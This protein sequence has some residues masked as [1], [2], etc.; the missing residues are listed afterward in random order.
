MNKFLKKYSFAILFSILSLYGCIDELDFMPSP[1]NTDSEK[2]V[3]TLQLPVKKGIISRAM[4]EVHEDSIAEM[5]ILAFVSNSGSE[6]LS[7]YSVVNSTDIIRDG[8]DR[9]KYTVT[10]SLKTGTYSSIVLLANSNSVLSANNSVLLMG[11][12]RTTIEEKLIKELSDGNKWDANSANP[13]AIPMF[14]EASG[15]G[16]GITISPG[17]VPFNG[18][19]MTRIMARI[20]FSNNES[21]FTLQEIYLCNFRRDGQLMP[22]PTAPTLPS[23]VRRHSQPLQYGTANNEIYVFEQ[24][25]SD[26]IEGSTMP[27]M[28]IG[29]DYQNSGVI[30]YYRID[31]VN[32]INE[33]TPQ[34]TN[35]FLSLFRN[36]AYNIIIDEVKG[37]GYA[38]VADAAKC[39]PFNT[40]TRILV[41]D[42][43]GIENILFDGEYYL[44]ISH[45]KMELD[46]NAQT[47]VLHVETDNPLG[48]K[49]EQVGG[50]G[51][52]SIDRLSPG[53]NDN[54][55]LDVTVTAYNNATQ[56][57]TAA[58]N[59]NA[60]R[61]DYTLPV[62]QSFLDDISLEITDLMGNPINEVLFMSHPLGN[63]SA[64]NND[65]IVRWK[66]P[67]C[68]IHVGMIGNR[69]FPLPPTL[70]DGYVLTTGQ[71]I[72]TYHLNSPSAF[73]LDEIDPETGNPFIEEGAV[74]TF[75]VYNG[76]D[77][78]T[79][80]LYIRHQCASIVFDDLTELCYMGHAYSFGVRSNTLW[81]LSK[82]ET[83]I[84]GLFQ[85]VSGQ[86]FTAELNTIGGN[87]VL[88]GSI[89]NMRLDIPVYDPA[90][91]NWGMGKARRKIRLTFSDENG[92]FPDVTKTLIAILPDA[93]SFS[94]RNG[95]GTLPTVG[96]GKEGRGGYILIP[97]RKL[98][99]IWEKELGRPLNHSDL[100]GLNLNAEVEW[101]T[102]DG[103]IPITG[104][105]MQLINPLN[106]GDYRDYL[107]RVQT[108]DHP[109][110]AN[111]LGNALISIKSNG[112]ILWS[113]HIWV[114]DYFPDHNRGNTFTNMYSNMEL[115]SYN[116]GATVSVDEFI[117][118]P[119]G[120]FSAYEKGIAG[121]F[122]Q[123]GRKDPFPGGRLD[124][125]GNDIDLNI[126]TNQM[127]VVK[128]G[129]QPVYT[130][131]QT[132]TQV[133]NLDKS[134]NNPTTFYEWGSS[135]N[136]WYT[137][138][139]NTKDQNHY[140]WKDTKN[141]KHFYDPCPSGWKIAP[142]ADAAWQNMTNY[143]RWDN[144]SYSQWIEM[145][146]G[147]TLHVFAS[148]IMGGYNQKPNMW[149]Y[150][151]IFGFILND[152]WDDYN[153]SAIVVMEDTFTS[154]SIDR[155]VGANVRC[156]RDTYNWYGNNWN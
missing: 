77:K 119:G 32:R 80:A 12:S 2:G 57:R 34:A 10:V 14:G 136:D 37:A 135:L 137:T 62:E 99:W 20:N 139:G 156:A 92:I 85:N 142:S 113:Y 66:G 152:Y 128:P 17:T 100:G 8:I 104:N 116:L 7:F 124:V 49:I 16:T 150:Y 118:T 96:D 56:P 114:S 147:Q 45:E 140:L 117:P 98:F 121:L 64:H 103:L 144:T 102:F 15:G 75:E 31:F 122:Y 84:D 87:D 6:Q 78:I 60:G 54:G 69:Q 129:G 143:K 35:K 108:T 120:T 97:I 1:D 59:I 4:A 44:A 105:S 134:I 74:I 46:K 115:M 3:F 109:T 70:S 145:P 126:H 18:I 71:E 91:E 154:G 95:G 132:P 146:D 153:A 61:L 11:T 68:K 26:G 25:P 36:H 112:E 58:F 76:T 33:G 106:N 51:W 127:E 28:I 43:G 63:K 90:T 48:W 23:I 81:K 38:T 9:K 30:T 86:D 47:E 29:G 138:S 22:G 110:D 72:Y 155:Y 130:N 13:E 73:T 42:D 149:I 52:L 21:N 67:A 41:F 50:A 141:R 24:D 27:F 148:G 88:T 111:K 107:I 5:A 101:Q 65:F 82:I 79:K 151:R 93:N 19:S 53:Q 133:I 39:L 94:V 125:S 55:N 131:F 83:E 89:I 40:V 123:W